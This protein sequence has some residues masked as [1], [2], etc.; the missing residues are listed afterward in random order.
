MYFIVEFIQVGTEKQFGNDGVFGPGLRHGNDAIVDLT[1]FA[2][3]KS[4]IELKVR[5]RKT[6]CPSSCT[7]GKQ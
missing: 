6:T 5:G 7:P 1:G 4:F 2:P 3:T